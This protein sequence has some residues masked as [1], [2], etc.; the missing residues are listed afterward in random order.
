M[1]MIR[2]RPPDLRGDSVAAAGAG[3][4]FVINDFLVSKKLKP[5]FYC[6]SRN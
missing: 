1:A 5:Q 2:A 6:L 3:G 4:L